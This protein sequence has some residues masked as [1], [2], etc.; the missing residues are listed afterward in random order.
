MYL[1]LTYDYIPIHM[2]TMSLGFG[3]M[4]VDMWIADNFD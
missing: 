4:L 1:H 2:N 3:N